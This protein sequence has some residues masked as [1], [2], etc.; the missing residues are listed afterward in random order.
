MK[1]FEKPLKCEKCGET[2]FEI[3]EKTYYT[4][5]LYKCVNLE[6]SI[7]DLVEGQKVK[8]VK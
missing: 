2:K 8:A 4:Y 3:D 7:R 1:K 5:I 6:K